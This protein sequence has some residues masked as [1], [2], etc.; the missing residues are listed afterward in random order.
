VKFSKCP[1][2]VIGTVAIDSIETP[3][4]KQ[5]EVFGGSA[6][7]F[8]YAASFFSPVEL[9]AVVGKDFPEDY[10]NILSERPIGLGHLSVHPKGETFRWQG[11]YKS[12]LNVAHTIDTK[13][14][15]L[16]D[17]KP[18]INPDVKPE[19][20]FLANIDPALQTEVL[21]QVHRSHCELVACDTMNFWITNKKKELI[22]VLKRVDLLVINDGEARELTGE[23]NLIKAAR[24]IQAN[25]PNAVV[26]KKGEHG[27][28]LFFENQMFVLPA[29]P[30]E[31][32]FD[33]TGAGDSFAG[34]MMGYLAHIK[35]FNFDVLR[36]AVAYGTIVASFTVERFGLDR[37]REISKEDI[38]ERLK[39]F[40]S[41]THV[42]A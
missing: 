39:I 4:G 16:L 33:P 20:L 3:Y 27:V 38:E 22:D 17:F 7:Y 1:L 5:G 11:Q 8:S 25:G 35:Q 31:E 28:L 15:V 14:N 42:D 34:G 12:D 24:A 36:R 29:Y 6:S 30:L 32:V 21:N 10:R 40:K 9:V 23:Y 37:L 41:L 19:I 13:L 26:I 2:M 18:K